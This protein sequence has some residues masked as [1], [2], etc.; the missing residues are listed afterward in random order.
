MRLVHPTIVK[1]YLQHS[2]IRL[3]RYN[4]KLDKRVKREGAGL[5]SAEKKGGTCMLIV[6]PFN[7]AAMSQNDLGLFI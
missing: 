5:G 7:W 3:A 1:L 6:S 2:S 4:I